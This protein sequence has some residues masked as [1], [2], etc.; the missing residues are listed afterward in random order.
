MNALKKI[1]YVLLAVFVLAVAPGCAHPPG[2]VGHIQSYSAPVV[3]A[4]WIRNGQP[5]TFED[6]LWFPVDE[7]EALLDSEVYLVGEYQGVQIFVEKTDV[8]P[9]DR[10]YTKFDVNKFR[11]YERNDD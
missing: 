3:E 9:Y 8:R 2:N 1:N 4:E 7:V 6:E 5:I 11:I 10:L